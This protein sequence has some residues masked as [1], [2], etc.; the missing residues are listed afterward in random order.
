MGPYPL[1]HTPGRW[2]HSAEMKA[3]VMNWNAVQDT[4]FTSEE[5]VQLGL[6]L[7]QGSGVKLNL[8]WILTQIFL[9]DYGILSILYL[10]SWTMIFPDVIWNSQYLTFETLGLD[11]PPRNMDLAIFHHENL[12]AYL[13]LEILFPLYSCIKIWNAVLWHE[14]WNTFLFH[15]I[16]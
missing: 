1:D 10:K 16:I 9:L 12:S 15:K 5:N 2:V 7:K 11:F 4:S 14:M 13:S 6:V 3:S 8:L